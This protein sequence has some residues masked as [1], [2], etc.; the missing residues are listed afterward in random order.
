MQQDLTAIISVL[1][2]SRICVTHTHYPAHSLI[3][4]HTH[5]L[6]HHHQGQLNSVNCDLFCWCLSVF[7]SVSLCL[8]ASLSACLF[9]C[10]PLSLPASLTARL[11]HCPPVCLSHCLP[12]S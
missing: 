9:H 1:S 6:W 7:L 3:H 2:E 4:I 10:L 12:L 11:S 8:S 5:N